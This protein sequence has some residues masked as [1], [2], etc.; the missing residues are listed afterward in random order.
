MKISE[1]LK[2]IKKISGLTQESLA[3]ELGVSFATVNSWINNKSI[4]HKK[5]QD[6]ID[7][8]YKKHTGE[9]II[10]DS[11]LVAKK[12]LL[13]KKRKE[14][15]N[16]IKKITSREDLFNE[17]ILQLTYNS[18]SIEG[19]T[20]TES[21]TEA[22]LFRNANIKDKS[23]IEHLEAKN[24]QTVLKYLFE[25]IDKN[26]NINESLILKFHSILMNGIRDDA[27]RY[28]SH[29]VRIVGSNVPTANYLRVS[30]LMRNLFTDINKKTDD[31]ITHIST[32][33]SKFEQI[34]PF[35]DGNGRIG[36]VIMI[37]MLLRENFAP[38]IISQENR[39]FY[40]KYL[41]KSQ[42]QKEFSLLENFICDSIFEGYE[43]IEE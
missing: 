1:T 33:H 32:V 27:G 15:K 5:K 28:R 39:N 10:P 6:K 30:E 42:I 2:L 34:H 17:F 9:K 16:I 4:P 8:L 37:A 35:S 20:L 25:I 38:A 21:D 14:S 23:L 7:E 12:N 43:I 26:L 18:N 3:K 36:R 24:H 19:S 13:Y 31:V 22:I 40:Y 29:G 11:E 41:Q